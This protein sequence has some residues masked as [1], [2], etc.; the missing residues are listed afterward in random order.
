ML[1]RSTFAHAQNDAG[2]QIHSL[3]SIP[4]PFLKNVLETLTRQWILDSSIFV[5][6]ANVPPVHV[7]CMFCDFSWFSQKSTYSKNG[8]KPSPEPHFRFAHATAAFG[9]LLWLLTFCKTLTPALWFCS[10]CLQIPC[11]THKNACVFNE[12]LPYYEIYHT[13]TSNRL[14]FRSYF[15]Q[16]MQHS[17][18]FLWVPTA[19]FCF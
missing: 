2:S 5:P 11:E 13:I 10:D 8:L 4:C 15:M 12:I 9:M 14:Q 3:A 7:W 17:C 6:R 1:T 16:K 18:W 19:C